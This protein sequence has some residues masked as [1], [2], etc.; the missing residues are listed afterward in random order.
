[1]VT[2]LV[3]FLVMVNNQ[4]RRSLFLVIQNLKPKAILSF[5]TENLKLIWSKYLNVCVMNHVLIMVLNQLKIVFSMELEI[6]IQ[7][8]VYKRAKKTK[9]NDHFITKPT[10]CI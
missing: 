9:K 7:S 10:F 3:I 8:G 2:W 5:H 1:M 4:F 6:A